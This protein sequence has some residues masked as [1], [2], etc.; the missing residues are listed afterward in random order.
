MNISYKN[1]LHFTQSSPEKFLTSGKHHRCKGRNKKGIITVRHRGGGH[2]R[3]YRQIDFRR[4]EK[5]IYGK[6][7]TIEYDPNRNAHISL[8]CYKNGKK[9]YILSPRGIMIGDTILSGPKASILIGNA[10][11]LTNIPVGTTIHNIETTHGKGGQVARAAGTIAK[12][13]AKEGQSAVLKLPS[14]ELRL[15][16]YNCSATVGQV[17][18][19]RSNNKIFSKA[20]SKRWIGKRSEVRGIVMNAVDHPHGGGEGKS[21]IGRK[22]PITPWGHCTL[23]KKTRKM[24]RYSDTFILRRQTKL[25]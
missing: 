17:G 2:K 13:I 12:L 23:G 7:V 1:I 4:K 19:I 16:P 14:G 24:V 9:S 5:D 10:L 22:T 6:I 15:I 3:L 18:N 21:P 25:E 11:P 20:G 8:I